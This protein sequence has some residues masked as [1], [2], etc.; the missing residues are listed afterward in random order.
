MNILEIIGAIAVIAITCVSMAW[1]LAYTTR[2][3]KGGV[4]QRR[5]P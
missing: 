1:I 2:P 4:V 5:K 3:P